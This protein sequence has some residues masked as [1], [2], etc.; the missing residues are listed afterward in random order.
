MKRPPQHTRAERKA[1]LLA[2]AEKVIDELLDWEGTRPR[3][4]LTEIEDVVL[5]FRQR[6]GQALTQNVVDAQA[7]QPAVPGPRCRHCGREMHVKGPKSKVVETRTGEIKA[8]RNYYH[9]AHCEQGL[10]PLDAQLQVRETHWSEAIAHQAVWLY[11]QV[12]DDLAEQIL[13][14]IGGLSIS[15]TSIWRRAQKWGEK[16]R[17]AEETRAKVAVG[18]PQRGQHVRG[19]VPHDRPMGGALD[20]GMINIRQEKWKELKVGTVFE[21]EPREEYD[22]ISQA[23]FAQA[24]AVRNSYVAVLG[25]PATFGQRLWA[26]AVRREFP[27]SGDNIILGD[28]AV[29][30]WNLAGEHFGSSRQ[31]VDWY[32]AKE[33]LHTAANLVYG[34]GSAKAQQWVKAMETPLYQGHAARLAAE[35]TTLAQTHRRVGKALRQEAGYFQNNQRR[36]Q[37]QETREDGFPI[38][39]GMVESG[40]KQFRKRFTGPGMRWNRECVNR[41][42]PVRAAIMSKRFDE[43]WKAVYN[44]PPN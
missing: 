21:I 16:I 36:M 35:L 15:D 43:V 13:Q 23:T 30:I 31:V 8:T 4:T 2:H 6:F 12:E 40:I 33:H 9:C 34:E 20:G 10:F 37:Y 26:E 32:H 38:G 1:E 18:L 5:Q 29:W 28:G 19:Q 7:A 41:V 27:E 44:S 25:G 42:L 11:G 39:S 3:P 14:K 22:P 17:V 24:H